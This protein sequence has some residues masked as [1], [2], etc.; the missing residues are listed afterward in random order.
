[1]ISQPK[2]R[3]R[4]T[5]C[6]LVPLALFLVAGCDQEKS[7]LQLADLTPGE[8][9]IVERMVVLERAKTAALLDRD[10]GEALLDS[11]AAA[12]GDSSLVETKAGA[13]AEPLRAEAF[14]DLLRRVITA[15]QESLLT[16]PGTERLTRPVPDPAPAAPPPGAAA[17]AS[18]NDR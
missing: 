18:P 7:P 9:L 13:P 15:E 16:V 6:R 2:L 8:Y 3:L 1:M 11:L 10:A 12:W 5:L 17:A 14:G 4:S